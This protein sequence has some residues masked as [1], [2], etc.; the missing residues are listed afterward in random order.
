MDVCDADSVVNGVNAANELVK[1]NHINLLIC[2]AG[3]AH[4]A[5]FI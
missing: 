5:R 3:F 1:P 4:P 2:N